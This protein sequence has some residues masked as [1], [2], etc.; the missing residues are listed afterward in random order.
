M[1]KAIVF[2]HYVRFLQHLA[3]SFLPFLFYNTN[4]KPFKTTCTQTTNNVI[5]NEVNSK[6]GTPNGFF[7]LHNKQKNFAL[8]YVNNENKHPTF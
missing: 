6:W 5:V 2:F 3:N 8:K 1:S 4:N 7:C